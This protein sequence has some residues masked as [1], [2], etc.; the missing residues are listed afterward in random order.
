MRAALV[1]AYGGPEVVS[2]GLCPDPVPGPRDCLVE[3]LASPV[4]AGDRRIRAAHFPRGMGLLGRLAL[5]WQGPRQPIL[6]GVLCGR[7]IQAGSAR[8]DLQPGQSV[9]ALTGPRMGAHAE[10]CCLGPR[11]ALLPL[12]DGL[13]P[14]LT[15]GLLFGGTAALHFLRDRARMQPGERLLVIGAAGDV[16]SAA[17]QIGLA[18]GAE[19]SG[20]ARADA[21]EFVAG[22]GATPLRPEDLMQG[23]GGRRGPLWDLVLDATGAYPPSAL[24]Q[25]LAPGGRL[26]LLAADLPTML[27]AL[28]KPQYLT[29][30]AP[31]SPPL[32]G[33]VLDLARRGHLRP[34]LCQSFALSEAA[35]AHA[36]AERRGRLGAVVLTCRK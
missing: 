25:H 8:P 36:H 14:V 11:A 7:V 27:R 2:V 34:A 30:M 15:A 19:V 1:K 20:L 35:K 6:G 26:A 12:P 22:L 16:G 28:F 23:A 9:A 5:G 18:M 31:D 21:Q 33:D 32:L 17:V 4:T 29:G 24:A 3:V 13:D 10:L